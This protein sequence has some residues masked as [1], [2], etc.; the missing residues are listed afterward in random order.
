MAHK[1]RYDLRLEIEDGDLVLINDA[2]WKDYSLDIYKYNFTKNKYFIRWGNVDYNGC[3][4]WLVSFPGEKTRY[5]EQKLYPYQET[6]C[7]SGLEWGWF[8]YSQDIIKAKILKVHP[9]Y[10]YL[11]NKVKYGGVRFSIHKLLACMQTWKEHPSEVEAL[12][13]L[14]YYQ[15]ACNKNLYRLTKPKQK[16]IIKAV[17]EFIKGDSRSLEPSLKTLQSYCKSGLQFDEW[18]AYM[19]WNNWCTNANLDSVET[20]RYCK[21]KNIDKFRYHDMLKMAQDQGHNIEDPYWKYPNNPN[22][23]HDELVRVKLELDKIRQEKESAPYW[24]QLEKIAKRNKLKEGIDIG[25]GY[26]LFMPTCYDEYYLAATE[27]HQCILASKYYKKVAEGRSLLLMIWHD[28]KPSSTCEIDFNKNIIQ[29]YANERAGRTSDSIKPT[30]YEKAA[31]DQFLLNFKP[32]KVM[33]KE[34]AA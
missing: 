5:W 28:G 17:K 21:R 9:E 26:R 2:S 3:A 4:G 22:E 31:M 34:A 7:W 16:Q 33:F 13:S 32:K 8:N 18:Y 29:F 30:E 24:I 14:E 23:V 10:K 12:V 20:Y 11:L 19:C 1:A 6:Q 27:L 25:N 15:L